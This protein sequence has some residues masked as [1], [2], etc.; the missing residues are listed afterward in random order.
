MPNARLELPKDPNSELFFDPRYLSIGFRPRTTTKAAPA[1]QKKVLRVVIQAFGR[2]VDD[3][4]FPAGTPITFGPSRKNIFPTPTRDLPDRHPLITYNQDG[5]TTLQ[6]NKQ[7]GGVLQVEKGLTPLAKAPSIESG[8]FK[9]YQLPKNSRGCLE[10]GTLLIY[11]EEIPDPERVPPIAIW[12][13]LSDP[14][15]VRW[16]W[17]SLFF[18]GLLLLLILLLPE[19]PAKV[20]LKSLSPKFKRI[21]IQPQKIKPYVPIQ[22]IRTRSTVTRG[23][24]G[25][26]GK[27]AKA[28][29]KEG[30]RGKG[31]KGRK[32]TKKQLAKTGVLDFF[33]KADKRRAFDDILGGG[34]AIPKSADRALNRKGRY[35]LEGE[36]KLRSGKG[37]QGAS[38]GG[39]GQTT[40]IG[41]GLSTSGRGGG[42][43]GPGL[44][45]FGTGKSNITVSASI[46]EEEVYI[47][48][49]IPKSVIA[50]IIADHM[51]QVRY[52]Y[53]KELVRNPKLRGKISTNFII[54]LRGSVTSARVKK[55]SM[56]N[57]AVER[58]V[59]GVIR[60]L[61]FPKPGGG[62]VEVSY[63]F[64][65]RVAG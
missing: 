48:G 45:D 53:E 64:L 50:K 51:G 52:C 29:G 1:A 61:P 14:Y 34:S 58:C 13:N 10:H 5:T 8:P 17:V 21:L 40:S 2:V 62:I 47:V 19:A 44:A 25:L 30:K 27:G 38:R 26:A 56:N 32:M 22:A 33:S 57:A 49:N 54:G 35:G 18:H 65:F 12:R 43:T 42:R 39:G 7:F 24:V 63:P 60:R 59:L 4:F 6:L 41:Q 23:K 20:E 46:D 3:R 31:V 16:L 9:V 28:R 37:L 15:F 11:F 36:R 55:T